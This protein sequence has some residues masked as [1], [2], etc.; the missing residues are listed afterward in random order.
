[1]L[2]AQAFPFVAL[3][4]RSGADVGGEERRVMSVSEDDLRLFFIFS[5]IAWLVPNVAFFCTIDLNY[6]STFF[7]SQ[8][9]P[10]YTCELFETSRTDKSKFRAAF[11]NNRSFTKTIESEIQQWV[12]DNIERWRDEDYEWFKIEKIPDH[13]LPAD[14]YEAEGGRGRRRSSFAERL[15]FERLGF[16][17]RNN[18]VQV[19]PAPPP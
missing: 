8:T 3:V 14:V 11:K 7:S 10:Q 15:G 9:A 16:E 19:H 5:F 6:T 12:S 4:L 18:S 2:W 17:D 1:M 13:M